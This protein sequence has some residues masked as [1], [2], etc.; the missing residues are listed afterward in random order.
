MAEH[1]T[2]EEQ[3]E[4][5]KRWWRENGLQLVLVVVLAAGG[6]FGWQFW[7]DRNAQLAAD[8]SLIY[9]NL[10]AAMQDWDNEGK[11][12]QAETVAA[13]AETLKSLNPDSQYA[14]YSA[15]MLARLAVA[16]ENFE[17]ATKELQWILD[18]NKDVALNDLVRLR[19]ARIQVALNNNDAALVLLDQ[20]ETATFEGVYQELR[21][22]ILAGQGEARDARAA[23]QS[24]LDSL[25]TN[26]AGGRSVLEL[27][28]SQVMPANNSDNGNDS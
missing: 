20:R 22:D 18:N 9:S 14:Y 10:V 1:L 28:L 21:G 7:Q 27:K 3:L 11:P 13:H 8:S 26:D 17:Q 19:L 24:A 5:L 4:A 12:E 6:W 15:M 25:D 23:Y 2:D 16:D